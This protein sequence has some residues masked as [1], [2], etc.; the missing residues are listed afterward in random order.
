MYDTPIIQQSTI[1]NYS[2]KNQRDLLIDTAENLTQIGE[3]TLHSFTKEQ[4]QIELYLALTRKNINALST[5]PLSPALEASFTKFCKSYEK[6]EQEYRTGLSD[7]K[8]W[9][10][11][12]MTWA[13]TLTENVSLV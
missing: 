9:A 7:Q 2:V 12:V 6:L 3:W 11:E 1:S 5:F 10:T 8:K 13:V 4:E